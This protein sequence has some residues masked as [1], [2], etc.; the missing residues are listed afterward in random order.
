MEDCFVKECSTIPLFKRR[1]LKTNKFQRWYMVLN[2][3]Y[4]PVLCQ[5]NS[6]SYT[7]E[8]AKCVYSKFKILTTIAHLDKHHNPNECKHWIFVSD[9]TD[10]IGTQIKMFLT[11]ADSF[12]LD[13]TFPSGWQSHALKYDWDAPPMISLSLY[14]H[15]VLNRKAEPCGNFSI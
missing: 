8:Q 11:T 7:P 4:L 12:N 2:T 3:I 13:V 9:K 6:P 15:A 14:N 1:Y 5:E 10:S